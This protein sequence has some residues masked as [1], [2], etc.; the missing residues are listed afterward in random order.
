MYKLFEKTSEISP[1]NDSLIIESCDKIL[2][3]SKKCYTRKCN[4]DNDCFSNNCYNNTCI[5]NTAKPLYICKSKHGHFKCLK[6]D[7][8]RCKHNTECYSSYFFK[9]KK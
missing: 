8:E 6:A 2:H 7:Q 1:N 4:N 5:T 3:K 9:N